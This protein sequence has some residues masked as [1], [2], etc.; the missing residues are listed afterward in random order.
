MGI[1]AGRIGNDRRPN[2][3]TK[4]LHLTAAVGFPEF[5]VSPAAAAGELVR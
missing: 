2:R 4:A 3:R 5:D 1:H